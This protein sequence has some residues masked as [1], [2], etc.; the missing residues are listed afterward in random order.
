MMRQLFLLDFD[1]LGECAEMI[2]SVTPFS[3]CVRLRAVL[4]N[5]LSGLSSM[6]A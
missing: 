6:A 3:V 2:A 1:A 5:V 4:A